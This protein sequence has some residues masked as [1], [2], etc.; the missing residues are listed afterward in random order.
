MNLHYSD[1][2][3]GK[4]KNPIP[5]VNGCDDEQIP[6]DYLYVMG[7][8]ETSPMN[9]NRC[10]TSLQVGKQ[11]ITVL[12]AQCTSLLLMYVVHWGSVYISLSD[13]WG[14]RLARFPSNKT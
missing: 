9:I 7:N 1:L 8:I 13:S 12:P 2:S 10:I 4:E 14:E 11:F 3:F 6:R 5:C